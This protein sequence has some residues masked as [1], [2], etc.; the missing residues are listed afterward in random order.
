[1]WSL[2]CIVYLGM[3]FGVHVVGAYLP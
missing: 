2:V 3:V 1:L